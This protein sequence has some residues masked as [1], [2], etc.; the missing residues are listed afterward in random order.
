MVKGRRVGGNE[1]NEHED[2][3]FLGMREQAAAI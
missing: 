1:R 2:A 3:C